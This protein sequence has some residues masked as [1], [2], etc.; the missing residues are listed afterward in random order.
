MY[1]KSG[2]GAVQSTIMLTIIESHRNK[3]P[4]PEQNI[5]GMMNLTGDERN[6]IISYGDT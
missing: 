4:E 5:M 3:R 2:E 6:E 1:Q